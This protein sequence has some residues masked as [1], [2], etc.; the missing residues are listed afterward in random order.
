MKSVLINTI[1]Y[2]TFFAVLGCAGTNDREINKVRL[3]E[4][5]GTPVDLSEYDGKT[6][7]INFWATWCKPCIQ[8]MPTIAEAQ[9]LKTDVVFLLASDEEF[10]Q[11]EKFKERHNY[12][13]HYVRLE[14]MEALK[15]KA[16][17]TTFIF[18]SE[19]KLKFSETGF[20]MWNDPANIK[21]INSI[22]KDY[23]K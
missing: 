19:G 12:G 17:P 8:E 18:N 10:S 20:R 9:K 14:N 15:I 4:L 13:F 16:L 1:L 6:V 5:D 7:F 22:T 23:E 3:K 11:I 2:T 21:L